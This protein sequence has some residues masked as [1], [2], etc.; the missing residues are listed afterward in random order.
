MCEKPDSDDE[1]HGV[2]A[3]GEEKHREQDNYAAIRP[4]IP[5][6]VDKGK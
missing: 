1:N 3:G 5:G 6:F 4:K 2:M